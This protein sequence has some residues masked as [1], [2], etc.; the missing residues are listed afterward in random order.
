[1]EYHFINYSEYHFYRK[2]AD[3][4][5]TEAA[6]FFKLCKKDITNSHIIKYFERKYD[7]MFIFFSADPYEE[8]FRDIG[9]RIP[10]REEIKYRGLVNKCKVEFVPNEV[11]SALSGMTTSSNKA[12]RYVVHINQDASLGRVI[13]SI[14]H[15]LSHIFAHFED[16]S[17][18]VY[19]AMS[20]NIAN[21]SSGNYPK[22][23][24]PIEDEAN[25]LASLFF[26]NDD[27]LAKSLVS[28]KS[29]NDLLKE[30]NISGSAL[31]NR[32]KNFLVY[33]CNIHP[34]IA[35][36]LSL[37]YRKGFNAEIISIVQNIQESVLLEGNTFKNPTPLTNSKN[38][39]DQRSG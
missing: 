31:L 16:G 15:E 39:G 11:T 36:S 24:Q 3:S 7:L 25:I 34:G 23:L 38:R 9:G 10:G 13:F 12:K 6:N 21:I 14:L 19:A 28:N 18:Q 22:E 33:N 20:S 17:K 26:I 8:F 35:Q 4:L 29:F 30:N 5:I 2:K 32:L 1:M 37:D 27:R